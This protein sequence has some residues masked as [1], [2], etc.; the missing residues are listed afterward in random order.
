MALPE[1]DLRILQANE[2]TMLA[3]VRTGLSLMAFGFVISRLAAWLRLEHPGESASPWLGVVVIG[4]GMACNAIGAHRF[5]H[6]RRAIVSGRPIV[7]SSV[8]PVVL[9]YGVVAMGLG[10]IAYVLLIG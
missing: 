1:P 4:F 10:A 8:G 5:L 2:R 9:A 3:W 6:A 7:P